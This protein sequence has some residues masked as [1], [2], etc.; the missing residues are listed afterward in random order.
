M[1]RLR[2]V[3]PDYRAVLSASEV[4]GFEQTM[5]GYA[6][7]WCCN[8]PP[9]GRGAG[10]IWYDFLHDV[11]PH[12]DRFNRH[13][14]ETWFPKSAPTAALERGSPPENAADRRPAVSPT[15]AQWARDG[16]GGEMR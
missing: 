2:G 11:V 1:L 16:C 5:R 4:S 13:W 6:G 9:G 10:H 15:R 8:R 3:P 12:K 14:D 7:L